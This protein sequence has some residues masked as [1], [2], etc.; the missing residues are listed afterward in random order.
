MGSSTGVQPGLSLE[1]ED[2]QTV[3]GLNRNRLKTQQGNPDITG[4]DY[5]D[6]G[7]PDYCTSKIKVQQVDESGDSAEDR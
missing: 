4:H 7:R 3:G 2:L 6:K 5:K 1:M